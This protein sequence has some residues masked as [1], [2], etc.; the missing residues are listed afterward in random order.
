MDTL[1][2]ELK[3]KCKSLPGIMFYNTVW[4][5]DGQGVAT[6]IYDCRA[7]A[8]EAAAML[9]AIW[10]QFS[11]ILIDEPVT[12]PGATARTTR[13]RNPRLDLFANPLP[14]RVTLEQNHRARYRRSTKHQRLAATGHTTRI[15]KDT[16]IPPDKVPLAPGPRRSYDS[17]A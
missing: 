5:K 3:G 11:D 15:N 2:D 10:A 4:P 6:T 8:D 7:S 9:E 16:L 14:H 1:L 13:Q 17:K 12:A